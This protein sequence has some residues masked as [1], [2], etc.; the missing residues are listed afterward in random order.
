MTQVQGIGDWVQYLQQD[1]YDYVVQYAINAQNSTKNDK[2]IILSGP[3]RTGKSR[4]I[5]DIV[6]FVGKNEC[7]MYYAE[8]EANDAIY[9]PIY[10]LWAEPDIA[11][12]RKKH[13]QLLVNLIDY[14]QS[15]ISATNCIENVNDR[16]LEKSR[17][18]YMNHVF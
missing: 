12:T 16:L 9:Q 18:I 1:D 7:A 8:D 4:L 10:K 2:M 11:N 14:N 6:A 15:M 5:R 13:T 3:S 17:I